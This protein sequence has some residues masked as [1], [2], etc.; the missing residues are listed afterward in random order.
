MRPTKY[1]IYRSDGRYSFE[2]EDETF[3]VLH[4]DDFLDGRT[5]LHLFRTSEEASEFETELEIKV[6]QSDANIS[7]LTGL[8]TPDNKH[9][10]FVEYHDEEHPGREIIE[11]LHQT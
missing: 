3:A 2:K 9:A 4:P 11:I 7:W 8:I 5:E 1:I 6:N 10:I